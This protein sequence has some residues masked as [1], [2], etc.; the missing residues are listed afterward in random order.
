MKVQRKLGECG[1][2]FPL[3]T[4][5]LFSN[6]HLE[7]NY[8]S[9]MEG[10]LFKRSR[11]AFKSWNRYCSAFIFIN[12]AQQTHQLF[13]IFP[14]GDTLQFITINYYFKSDHR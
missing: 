1:F 5:T 9:N 14:L 2:I 12:V 11:N 8:S 10:Y 6:K 3:S 13:D 4:F 7:Y